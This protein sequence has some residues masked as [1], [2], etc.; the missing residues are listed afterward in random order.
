MKAITLTQP[1]A[2]L[3]ALGIKRIETRSWSTSHRGPLAIH[4]AK[5]WS[6]EDRDFARQ[7]ELRHV[8]PEDVE[9]PHG[10]VVATALLVDVLST[11]DLLSA[12]GAVSE[13]ERWLGDFR[14]RRFGWIL[15]D[16][17]ALEQPVPARGALQLWD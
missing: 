14:A 3:V 10:A 8:L 5:N 13:T 4:A 12:P 6:S 11:D 9:L 7:L 1:W 15:Q 17:V 16:V 2:T